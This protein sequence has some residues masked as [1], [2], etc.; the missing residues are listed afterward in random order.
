MNNT[1]EI[2]QNDAW[3]SGS[4][5]PADEALSLALDALRADDITRC[6]SCLRTAMTLYGWRYHSDRKARQLWIKWDQIHEKLPNQA[7]A[8]NTQA[9]MAI[10]KLYHETYRAV[11]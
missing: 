7:S 9:A 4:N 8:S 3:W 5:A 6:F 11:H 2:A 10:E 1:E